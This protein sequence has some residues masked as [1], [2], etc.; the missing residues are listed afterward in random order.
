VALF[1]QLDMKKDFVVGEMGE[2]ICRLEKRKKKF[3][4]EGK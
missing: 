1:N 2:S 4:G 3:A